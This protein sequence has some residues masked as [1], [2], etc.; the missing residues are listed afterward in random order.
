MMELGHE[1]KSCWMREGNPDY[2]ND[3]LDEERGF[4]T[5]KTLSLREGKWGGGIG[6]NFL[7]N[8]K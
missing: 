8:I 3:I 6:D 5:V 4:R 7:R 2:S 1:E